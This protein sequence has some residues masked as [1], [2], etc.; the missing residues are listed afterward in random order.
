LCRQRR[1]LAGT[2]R[3][4]QDVIRTLEMLTGLVMHVIALVAYMAIFGVNVAHLLLSLSSISLAFAFVFGNSLRTV[5]ESVVFLFMIRPYQVRLPYF[6][7]LLCM[8]SRTIQR[9]CGWYG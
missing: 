1:N 2:L 9:Y 8:Q 6:C 7:I 5:Y 3:D 4:N